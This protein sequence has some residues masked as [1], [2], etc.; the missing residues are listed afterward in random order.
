[1]AWLVFFYTARHILH[2]TYTERER[3]YEHSHIYIYIYH[4]KVSRFHA[5]DARCDSLWYLHISPG[6]N[7]AD[8][9]RYIISLWSMRMVFSSCALFPVSRVPGA[10][11]GVSGVCA[12][13]SYGA[14]CWNAGCEGQY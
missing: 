1:M 14:E 7:N 4:I 11:L 8:Q 3:K 2:H 9:S 12:Y 6:P 13:V 10:R 5:G